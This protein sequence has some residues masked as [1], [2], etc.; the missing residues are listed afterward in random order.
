MPK[1]EHVQA[2]KTRKRSE[3]VA[4]SQPKKMDTTDLLAEIDVALEGI[5]EA[6]ATNYLQKGGE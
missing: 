4:E 5:D 3:E 6:F 1:R 2:T